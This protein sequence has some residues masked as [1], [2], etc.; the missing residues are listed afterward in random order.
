MLILYKKSTFAILFQLIKMRNL[1]S[2]F[3]NSQFFTETPWFLKLFLIYVWGDGLIV[4]FVWLILGL[5][6]IWNWQI[7]V[8]GVMLF[9]FIRAFGE[10]IYWFSHQFSDRSYR[11]P[12]FGMKSLDNHAIYI[13]YQLHSQ[14]TMLICLLLIFW[15]L[16]LLDRY[17]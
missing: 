17:F 1:L 14:L 7:A 3:Q 16:G 4:G 13:L 12:D 10:M 6:A 15:W 8:L 9:V 5:T 11:P 2:K